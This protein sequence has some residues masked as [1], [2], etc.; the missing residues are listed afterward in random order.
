MQDNYRYLGI[1][2]LSV[3]I[4]G[5]VIGFL[6]HREFFTPEITEKETIKIDTLKIKEPVPVEVLKTETKY[7]QVPKIVKDTVYSE[8]IKLVYVN[9]EPNIVLSRVQKHYNSPNLYDI[10]ISG[11]DPELDSCYVFKE[12]VTKETVIKRKSKLDLFID[13]EY[14]FIQ[15]NP[16]EFSAGLEFEHK[17]GLSLSGGYMAGFDTKVQNSSYH[18]PFVRVKYSFN[19]FK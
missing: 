13:S 16:L 6:W 11:I 8:S 4:L 2:F 14:R 1:G 19:V 18:G 9:G 5:I 10:Y 12:T 7:I 17:S 15:N 3:L